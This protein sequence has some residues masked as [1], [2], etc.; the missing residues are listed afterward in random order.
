MF[1]VGRI[2][3]YRAAQAF[4]DYLNSRGITAQLEQQDEFV[5]IFVRSESHQ[6]VAQQE[7][8]EFLRNPNH[9][10]YQ[11]ASW[12]AGSTS[13]NHQTAQSWSGGGTAI[14]SFLA[15]TGIATKVIALLAITV[16]LVTGFGTNS[17]V[18]WFTFHSEAILNGQLH[19]L[20]SPIFLHFPVLGIPFL[21]LLFNLM[22]FWD[23]GGRLEKRFNAS[24]LIYHTV[25]I[26]LISNISQY[27]VS[28]SNSIFG[29]LS[30]VVFGLLGYCW[31]RGEIDP[32]LGFKLNKNIVIFMMIW[33]ALGFVGALGSIA[34]AAHLVGFLTG[35]ALAW[36]DV[37]VFKFR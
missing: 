2:N 8:N 35:L 5:I 3:S 18:F 26:G 28:S 14:K 1:P 9:P 36:L 15:R 27:L 19:R 6:T 22:W 31:L 20:I 29:G 13:T 24:L 16:T 30:G 11:A 33:M 12:N 7:L 17:L 23:L 10:K 21:H 34:N 25:V 32:R 37:K 4:C